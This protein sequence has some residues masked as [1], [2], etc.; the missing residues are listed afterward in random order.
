MLL[1]FLIIQIE[2]FV[3]DSPLPLK[4]V[5]IKGNTVYNDTTIFDILNIHSLSKETIEAGIG[6]VLKRYEEAGYP[7]VRVK[8]SKFRIDDGGISFVIEID[9]GVKFLIDEVK[10][11][12]NI[13][14]KEEVIKR[15]FRMKEAWVFNPGVIEKAKERIDGLEFLRVHSI[16]PVSYEKGS[17]KGFLL[18][19]VE[20]LSTSLFEGVV[21]YSAGKVGG[22]LKIETYNLFGTGRKLSGLYSSYADDRINIHIGYTEPWVFGY[23][24][25]FCFELDNERFDTLSM[26]T[27][28]KG[29]FMISPVFEVIFKLGIEWEKVIP[30]EEERFGVIGGT[31]RRKNQLLSFSSRYGT[32]G[33]DRV[34][35]GMERLF[36]RFFLS[37]KGD[38]FLAD[39]IYKHNLVRV[40]GANSIRGYE[41]GEVQGKAG[42][43]SNMEYRLPLG[44][45]NRFFPFID[46]GYVELLDNTGLFMLGG[47]IGISFLTPV[48]RWSVD[49]G[50]GR[51]KDLTEGKLHIRLKTGIGQ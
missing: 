19:N 3:V 15:E 36:Q 1:F 50:I 18:V 41:A 14:T 26:V 39:S 37:V 12:G 47:G 16:Q 45:E 33:I 4:K 23:P 31:H 40:G 29:C 28:L 35:A 46:F 9:E 42:V 49:Y 24:A 8:P 30:G 44:G 51:G 21:G 7:F 34:T 10:V 43:W 38:A 17:G 48:G 11:K 5:E 22:F 2:N 25:D 32:H 13:T 6:R 27:R 20:E